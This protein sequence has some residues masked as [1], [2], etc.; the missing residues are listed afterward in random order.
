M[1]KFRRTRSKEANNIRKI[2][3]NSKTKIDLTGTSMNEF[4]NHTETLFFEKKENKFLG[5]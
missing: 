5:I 2:N 3:A 1:K 4:I